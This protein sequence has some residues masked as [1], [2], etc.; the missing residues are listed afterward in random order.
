MNKDLVKKYGELLKN[1]GYVVR[2]DVPGQF[3]QILVRSEVN[4]GELIAMTSDI[5][6]RNHMNEILDGML[7]SFRDEIKRLKAMLP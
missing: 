3:L 7:S 6:F 1:M 5:V 2:F 4:D